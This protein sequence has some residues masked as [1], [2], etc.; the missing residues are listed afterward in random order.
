MNLKM[1]SLSGDGWKMGLPVF[2]IQEADNSYSQGTLALA[3][4]LF[5]I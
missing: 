4:Y 5:D 2:S 3:P 1:K